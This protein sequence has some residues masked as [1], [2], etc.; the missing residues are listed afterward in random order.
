MK[1]KIRLLYRLLLTVIA[2]ATAIIVLAPI[3]ITFTNSLMSTSEIYSNYGA[4]IQGASGEKKRFI[5]HAV[6][7]KIIPDMVTL[8]QYYNV[9]IQAPDYLI[10]FWNSL[11]YVVPIVLFQLIVATLASYGFT[12]TKGKLS[13][14]VFFAYIILMM[15]P[16]Q[17]TLVPNYFVLKWMNLLNTRWS[18]WLTGIFS[19]FSVYLITKYMKRIPSSLMEAAQIDGATNWQVFWRVYLPISKGIITSCAI[20]I[21]IDYWNMVEQPL[22]FLNDEFDYPL[23]IFLSRI[24]TK[25]VGM[26]FAAASIYMFPP[27]LMFLYGEDAL[28]EGI[29]YQG[30]VKG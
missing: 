8:K 26:A 22:L 9:L 27:L 4:I 11:F 12:T 6:N 30:S 2:I 25:D 3:I 24:N 16:Y 29:A 7:L 1:K 23:S 5:A 13:A 20:L 19:P 10:K 28:V 14:I 21:F 15:M 18:I 17:V